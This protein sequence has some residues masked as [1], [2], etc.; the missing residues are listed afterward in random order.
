MCWNNSF[1]NHCSSFSAAFQSNSG[2][3]QKFARY[4]RS[5]VSGYWRV[6]KSGAWAQKNDEIIPDNKFISSLCHGDLLIFD[7][8]YL[9]EESRPESKF[10]EVDNKYV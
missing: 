8:V 5:L 10:H 9:P 4:L 2:G 6:W 7:M 1:K 3:I